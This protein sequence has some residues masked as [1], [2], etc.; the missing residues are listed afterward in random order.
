MARRIE[1]KKSAKKI[2]IL[3][4]FNLVWLILF[5]STFGKKMVESVAMKCWS[6]YAAFNLL[7]CFRIMHFIRNQLHVQIT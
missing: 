2:I 5:G 6:D 4:V 7:N 1:R 3:L